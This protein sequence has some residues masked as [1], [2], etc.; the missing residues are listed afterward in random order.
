M[1]RRRRRDSRERVLDNLFEWLMNRGQRRD[2]LHGRR[3]AVEAGYGDL[4][5]YGNAGLIERM[6]RPHGDLV[7]GA[8]Q[9]II[10]GSRRDHGSG[11]LNAGVEGGPLRI[12]LGF[13]SE[14][15]GHRRLYE[16][17]ASQPVSLQIGIEIERRTATCCDKMLDQRVS[18]RLF[19]DGNTDA[20]LGAVAM[21]NPRDGHGLKTGQPVG[22]RF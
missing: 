18:G 12:L 5:G 22:L 9:S 6:Q 3:D 21:S 4:S 8:D 7:S 2:E 14:S 10:H 11:R 19:V 16:G 15:A 1:G 17:I 13:K 20:L